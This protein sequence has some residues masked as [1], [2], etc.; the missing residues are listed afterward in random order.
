MLKLV[1][2]KNLLTRD[3]A[4]FCKVVRIIPIVRRYVFTHPLNTDSSR[5]WIDVCY[6]GEGSVYTVGTVEYQWHHDDDVNEEV[7]NGKERALFFR[8]R[9]QIAEV[10]SSKTVAYIRRT[11]A[12]HEG[13]LPEPSSMYTTVDPISGQG[14]G[15]TSSDIVDA[16][17][18]DVEL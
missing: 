2:K 15:R 8:R 3:P 5:W 16:E 14:F 1:L 13:V 7:I 4:S 10:A 18:V 17:M 9:Y 11:N 6:F 12:I